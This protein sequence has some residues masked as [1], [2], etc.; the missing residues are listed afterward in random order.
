MFGDLLHQEFRIYFMCYYHILSY[1]N[2]SVLQY[3]AQREAQIIALP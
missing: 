3:K 2:S 1:P